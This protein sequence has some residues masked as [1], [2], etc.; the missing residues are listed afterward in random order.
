MQFW[1]AQPQSEMTETRII[2]ADFPC[3]LQWLRPMLS[4]RQIKTLIFLQMGPPKLG[5]NRPILTSQ[6]STPLSRR[7]AGGSPDGRLDTSWWS[8][9]FKVN[10]IQ[11][12]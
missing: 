10:R 1:S 7:G 8:M 9:K 5:Y 4:P 3:S 11:S 2:S 12:F 6:K